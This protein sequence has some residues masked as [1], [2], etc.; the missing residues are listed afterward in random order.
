MSEK[1]NI[2]KNVGKESWLGRTLPALIYHT[3]AVL[4]N[5]AAFVQ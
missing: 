4:P 3:K 1:K 2:A 5:E